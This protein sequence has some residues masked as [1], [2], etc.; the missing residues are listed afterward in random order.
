[1]PVPG[2]ASMP[3]GSGFASEGGPVS[4]AGPAKTPIAL[5]NEGVRVT[6]GNQRTIFSSDPIQML[7]LPTSAGSPQKM[8]LNKSAFMPPKQLSTGG[9][10]K[11]ELLF[12]ARRTDSQTDNQ[13]LSQEMSRLEIVT[14]RSLQRALQNKI[15]QNTKNPMG[16][17]SAFHKLDRRSA[18][19]LNL[20]DLIAAVKGFN[21]VA[22]DELVSQLLQALDRDHDGVLS[23][24]EFVAGL[25]ADTPLLLQDPHNNSVSTRRYFRGLNFHHPLHNVAHLSALHQHHTFNDE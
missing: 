12:G 8:V 19:A 4:T 24:S 1:M 3:S 7:R 15:M 22:S 2:P 11:S 6:D 10:S 13:S 25:Q 20:G 21:L 16:L 14:M 23:L 9:P 5:H 17:W 18:H